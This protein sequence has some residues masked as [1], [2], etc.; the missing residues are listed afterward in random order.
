VKGV[1]YR[2]KSVEWNQIKHFFCPDIFNW[3]IGIQFFSNSP[4]YLL[5]K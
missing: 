3:I 2:F 4:N 1:G 5:L